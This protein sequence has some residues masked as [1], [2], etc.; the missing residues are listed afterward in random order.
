M[1]KYNLPSKC[2]TPSTNLRYLGRLVGFE[3]T[4]LRSINNLHSHSNAEITRFY[5][6]ISVICPLDAQKNHSAS[7][8]Q[9]FDYTSHKKNHLFLV[10]FVVTL[11]DTPNLS[12]IYYCVAPSFRITFASAST[13]AQGE[14]DEESEGPSLFRCSTRSSADNRNRPQGQRPHSVCTADRRACP[15]RIPRSADSTP[16]RSRPLKLTDGRSTPHGAPVY[17]Y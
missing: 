12:L 6:E 5:R 16:H 3:P 1:K 17:A 11:A 2:P 14:N 10:T 8:P 9:V 13:D 4:A 15:V 7:P